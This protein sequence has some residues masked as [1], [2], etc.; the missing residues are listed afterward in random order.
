VKR[1]QKNARK[2]S[3]GRRENKK[4]KVTGNIFKR[5]KRIDRQTKSEQTEKLG[6]KHKTSKVHEQRWSP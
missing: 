3:Y 6:C 2:F 1:K 4:E 5:V